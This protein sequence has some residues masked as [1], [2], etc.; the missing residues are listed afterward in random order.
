LLLCYGI[1]KERSA[2]ARAGAIIYGLCFASFLLIDIPSDGRIFFYKYL[3][4]TLSALLVLAE[5]IYKKIDM[6]SLWFGPQ[7]FKCCAVVNLWLFGLYAIYDRFYPLLRQLQLPRDARIYISESAAVVFSLLFAYLIARAP[8]VSDKPVRILSLCVGVLSFL[9]LF[10]VNSG[11][12]F[13]ATATPMIAV[14]AGLLLC[15]TNLLA[16]FVMRDLLL[17]LVQARALGAEWYPLALSAFFVLLT[18]QNLVTTLALSYSSLILTFLF[19]VTALAWILFGFIKRYQY[20]RLF[21]LALAFVAVVKLFVVDLT[22]WDEG[23]RI[24]SYF[25]MGLALL[26]ISFVYQYF[27]KKLDGKGGGNT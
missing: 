21:G 3:F 13:V 4:V 17:R 9:F 16:V 1:W 24:L 8:V 2:F 14:C 12:D 23:L 19:A 18:V 6:R 11:A 26:A 27:N 22:F 25:L 15:L 10:R 7:I 5:I 20:N